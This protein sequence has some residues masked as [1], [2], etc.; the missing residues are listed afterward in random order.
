MKIESRTAIPTMLLVLAGLFLLAFAVVG[1]IGGGLF[2]SGAF[3]L[4]MPVAAALA[5]FRCSLT[6]MAVAL[7][8]SAPAVLLALLV[9]AADFR[10]A[11]PWGGLVVVVFVTTLLA[12]HFGRYRRRTIGSAHADA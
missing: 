1:F 3:L 6:P 12:A 11:L 9:V 4:A 5:T 10:T 8:L 7:A 2:L